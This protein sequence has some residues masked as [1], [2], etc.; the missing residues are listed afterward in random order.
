MQRRRK[1]TWWQGINWWAV[2]GVVCTLLVFSAAACGLV[3]VLTSAAL[4][5]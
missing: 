5:W 1:A 3:Y 4:L 2:I